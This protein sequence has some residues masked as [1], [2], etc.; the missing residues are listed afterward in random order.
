VVQ[1]ELP[2]DAAPPARD[3][4]EFPNESPSKANISLDSILPA[5]YDSNSNARECS[6]VRKVFGR[7]RPLV[8]RLRGRMCAICGIRSQHVLLIQG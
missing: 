6:P 3:L 5:R 1:G 7:I 8:G 2:E 4:D